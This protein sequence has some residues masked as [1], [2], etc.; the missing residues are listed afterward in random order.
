MWVD[1]KEMRRKFGEPEPRFVLGGIY[2]W[3]GFLNGGLDLV[4]GFVGLVTDIVPFSL[5]GF[6]T[7]A[8]MTGTAFLLKR[9]K[10]VGLYANYALLAVRL[11]GAVRNFWAETPN[12]ISD[13]A[14]YAVSVF[15]IVVSALWLI[16]FYRRRDM[17]TSPLVPL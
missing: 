15:W 8:F 5:E 6:L 2:I 9:R 7:G 3:L 16:Y 12:E 10:S 14:F 1:A 17:F 4:F 11:F 13:L